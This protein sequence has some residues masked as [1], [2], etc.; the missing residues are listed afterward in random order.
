[1]KTLRTTLGIIS[2]VLFVIVMFQSCAVGLGNALED[3]GEV[4]GSA[5]AFLGIIMLTAGIIG[6]ATRKSNAGAVV[7]GCFYALG[8][9][10]GICNVGTFSDLMIWSVLSFIFAALFII[11]ALVSRNKNKENN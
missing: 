2:I 7:A 10:I 8:G 9:L 11:S 6:L 3:N 1:M 5:G 4:S